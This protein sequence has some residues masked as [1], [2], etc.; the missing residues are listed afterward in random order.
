MAPLGT[1]LPVTGP[2]D[3]TF[4]DRFPGR[5]NHGWQPGQDVW[6][7]DRGP[8]WVWGSGVG[9]VTV[10]FETAVSGPG[11]VA[12][13]AVDD[14]ALAPYEPWIPVDH[15]APEPMTDAAVAG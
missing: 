9:R 14:D 3:R 2:P 5:R 13:F 10:R 12:T 11:P 15:D 8:G 6:H 1:D 7:A 4:A